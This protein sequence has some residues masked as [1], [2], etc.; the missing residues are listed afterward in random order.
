MSC[1]TAPVGCGTRV[2]IGPAA[3]PRVVT[4]GTRRP[5][6]S[7]ATAAPTADAGRSPKFLG[8]TRRRGGRRH[9]DVRLP[10]PDAP[11]PRGGRGP[12]AGSAYATGAGHA[13]VPSGFRTAGQVVARSRLSGGPPSPPGTH[14]GHGVRG[15]HTAGTAY[16]PHSGT[17]V[18]PYTRRT[19]RTART[20][21]GRPARGRAVSRAH[22]VRPAV[23]PRHASGPRPIALCR[24]THRVSP[25]PIG[26]ERW[27]GAAGEYGGQFPMRVPHPI[28]D[29][30]LVTA[31]AASATPRGAN[32]PAPARW[33]TTIPQAGTGR[34]PLR[35]GTRVP[36][37]PSP[38]R[39]CSGQAFAR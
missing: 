30:V 10:R 26:R 20:P 2:E 36:T 11:V 12:R 28:C 23:S 24:R 6:T 33:A 19:G 21:P 34:D 22:T 13:R 38:R 15:R 4:A 37:A 31:S 39:P 32:P 14:H 25:S 17:C 18:P 16:V 8:D 29:L 9:R 5:D 7:R 1:L 3:P 35:A 27:A